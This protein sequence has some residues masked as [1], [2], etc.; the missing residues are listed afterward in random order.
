MQ[1]RCEKGA[2]TALI[3]RGRS[4][5][6]SWC[7]RSGGLTLR[8]G[9]L[10]VSQACLSDPF[11]MGASC[12]H[13]AT[14]SLRACAELHTLLPVGLIAAVRVLSVSKDS[15]VKNFLHC[16][17]EMGPFPG[18]RVRVPHKRRGANDAFLEG[19]YNGT[20]LETAPVLLAPN[21]VSSASLDM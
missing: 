12:P 17:L 13:L 14:P 20:N 5:L 4:W 10:Q 16:F 9:A 8:R 11:R 6:S 7:C 19:V 21:M 2:Q 1:S 3:G 18:L 15:L